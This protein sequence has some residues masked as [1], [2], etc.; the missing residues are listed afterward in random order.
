MTRYQRKALPWYVYCLSLKHYADLAKNN[1]PKAISAAVNQ[2]VDII[3]MSWTVKKTEDNH[4]GIIGLGE[5]IKL[6]LDQGIL[7]FCSAADTGAVT[8]V[9]YP[10]AY[11]QRRIFRI[12][13]ATADGRMWGPTGSPQNINFILPGHKVVSR[14]P[15]RE[16]ALPDDFE[17]RNGSSIATALAAGLAALILHCVRLGAIHTE[18]EMQQGMPS[19]MA[20]KAPEFMRV[21]NRDNMNGVL[22]AIGLDE[23]QQRFIEVW[24]RFDGPTQNLKA[25]NIELNSKADGTTPSGLGVIAK[26]ARDFISGINGG[27]S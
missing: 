15:H 9:E 11:D 1:P 6:A 24:K 10:W 18:L 13:A 7:L 16:G 14:N 17:E 19:A 2:N 3:S 5:A 20:V 26:L 21:K 4:S 12:G 25:P 27:A 23:G 8:E 22:K